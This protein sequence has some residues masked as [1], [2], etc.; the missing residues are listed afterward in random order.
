MPKNFIAILIVGLIA[1][2]G[3]GWYFSRPGGSGV[4][5]QNGIHWHPEIRITIL[6][7]PQPIPAGIGLI[8]QE[9]PIHTHESDNVIHLE[10]AG[11]V[12]VDDARVGKFFQIWGKTFNRN[13]I[14]DK[15]AGSEGALIMLV[16]GKE[17]S[18]FE[19]YPMRD[20]DKIE[21]IFEKTLEAR[22]ITVSASEFSFSPSSIIVKA[23]ERV[24]IIFQNNGNVPH[25]LVIDGLGVGTKIIGSG[26]TETVE[27]TA[28]STPGTH[29]FYCSIPG[30][31]ESGMEGSL[32]V[33]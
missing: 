6:G 13:C 11:R 31:R 9:M 30:H 28:P 27:I 15:C 3:L 19:N 29:A 18:E 32:I 21:I 24:K 22:E 16:N 33:E 25:N 4:I 14:F 8:P 10:F 5:A 1:L 23:G 17:N 7:E 2:L 12:T 20:K 26:K